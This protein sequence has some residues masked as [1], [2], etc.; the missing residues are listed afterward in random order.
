MKTGIVLQING[1]KATVL[2]N[3]GEFMQIYAKKHWK[4]GDVVSLPHTQKIWKQC[5]FAAAGILLFFC[6]GVGAE[7]IY[8]Q[9]KLLISMDINPSIEISVNQFNRIVDVQA[10]NED[11]IK[12]LS[13]VSV[14][15]KKYTD[16]IGAI[17]ASKAMEDYLTQNGDVLFAVQSGKTSVQNTAIVEALTEVTETEILEKHHN[18][19]VEYLIVSDEVIEN[20]HK[21][22]ITPGKYVYL[23]KLMEADP[24]VDIDECRHHS[25]SQLKEEIQMCEQNCGSQQTGPS[26]E[27]NGHHRKRHH[28]GHN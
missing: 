14:K 13:S 18:T 15:N 27:N 22:D 5:S 16:G 21:H 20:A 2:V 6:I 7:R 28:G 1:R 4:K 11:G 3:G 26:G 8:F 25:I 19:Q 24:Q 10:R 9:E 17:L 23:Q 12:V